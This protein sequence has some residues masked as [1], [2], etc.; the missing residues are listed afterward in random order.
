MNVIGTNQQ[1]N[2]D[3]FPDI[4]S[5]SKNYSEI[6]EK[7]AKKDSIIKK[8]HESKLVHDGWH[9]YNVKCFIIQNKPLKK[10]FKETET[11]KTFKNIGEI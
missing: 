7:I 11:I 1:K 6:I 2:A 3:K 8:F 9:E 5:P 10:K 4:F